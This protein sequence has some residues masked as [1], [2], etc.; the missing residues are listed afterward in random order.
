MSQ[1]ALAGKPQRGKTTCSTSYRST[2]YVGNWPGVTVEK[3]EGA[4]ANTRATSSLWNLPA[5][6]RFALRWK[7]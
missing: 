3:E 4:C 1:N 2:Q 7:R 5:S 6:I